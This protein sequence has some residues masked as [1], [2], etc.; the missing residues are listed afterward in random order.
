MIKY[1][2]LDLYLAGTPYQ[3]GAPQRFYQKTLQVI[4]FTKSWYCMLA[5]V[6]CKNS[7]RI[8][9]WNLWFIVF[10]SMQGTY[11]PEEWS[12]TRGLIALVGLC[13]LWFI[14]LTRTR[15]LDN[16]ISSCT[17][18]TEHPPPHFKCISS[19]ACSRLC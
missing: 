1:F 19:N 3:K 5:F 7:A 15:I 9:E 17:V 8:I 16:I 12:V 2:I 4:F 18:W 13:F 11:N 14:P 6:L 10:K